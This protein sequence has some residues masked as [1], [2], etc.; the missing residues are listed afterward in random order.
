MKAL[1]I[2]QPWAWLICAGFKDVENRTWHI[3]MPPL[4]NYPADPRRIYVHAPQKIDKEAFP[5]IAKNIPISTCQKWM[6]DGLPNRGMFITG[7]VIGEVDITGC[8]ERS[9]SPW[10]VGPY[11]FTLARPVLYHN[12]FPMKGMLGFFEPDIALPGPVYPE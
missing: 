7:A 12:P 5:W 8:V 6:V 3:H 10:F 9:D 2:K 1:S 4:L 11:G